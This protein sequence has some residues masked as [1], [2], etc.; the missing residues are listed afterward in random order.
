MTIGALIAK[1]HTVLLSHPFLVYRHIL[2]VSV[3]I[4]S[5]KDGEGPRMRGQL[6]VQLKIASTLIIRMDI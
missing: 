6:N 1:V 5:R 2:A 3:G 4:G